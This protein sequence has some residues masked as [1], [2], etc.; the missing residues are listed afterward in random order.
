MFAGGQG[1]GE[2]WSREDPPAGVP[3]VPRPACQRRSK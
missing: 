2:G 1:T 3:G